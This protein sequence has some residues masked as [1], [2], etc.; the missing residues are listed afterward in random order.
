MKRTTYLILTL[1]L[2][3]G[4]AAAGVVSVS[5]V[6]YKS[7]SGF[8]SGQVFVIDFVAD[9]STDKVSAII[10]SGQLADASGGDVS[11]DLTVDATAT[12]TY[13]RYSIG[14][15]GEPTLVQLDLTAAT[16]D[17][18]SELEQWAVNTCYDPDHDG[19]VEWY[20]HS[21]PAWDIADYK[22]YCAYRNGQY[23]PIGDIAS[24]DE[25]F[26]AE[27]CAEASGKQRECAT[28]SNG[29]TGVG[30]RTSLGEHV[31]IEW[32]GNL[33]TGE[34]APGVD[35]EYALHGNQFD[36]GWRIISYS[37]Y[38]DWTDYTARL[39]S[40]YEDWATGGMSRSDLETQ[41]D[42][43]AEQAASK[44]TD[45][46]L[47]AAT[48]VDSSFTDGQ[49][50]LDLANQLAYPAFTLYVDGAEYITVEKPTG[51]PKIVSTS[52]DTFGEVDTG[53]V[54]MTVENVGE[55][56]GSFAGRVTSCSDGFNFDSTTITQTVNPGERTTYEF[57]VSFTSTGTDGKVSGTCT[58]QVKG[59]ESR[60]M[61][62]ASV[63]GKQ[64]SECK[65]GERISKPGPSGTDV[66]YKCDSDGVGLI[67]LKT[68]PKDKPDT[69]MRDGE[70][71]C[72]APNVQE[73]TGLGASFQRFMS[74]VD[75]FMEDPLGNFMHKPL[76]AIDILATLLAV[77]AAFFLVQSKLVAPFVE[78]VSEAVG[79]N[80]TLLRLV[81]GVVIAVLAGYAT[82]ALISQLWVKI[83]IFVGAIVLMGAYVYIM[84]ILPG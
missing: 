52:G 64:A 16:K 63:T 42:Q 24:P 73:Q 69:T 2:L 79:V 84:A 68:C 31:K 6:N 70:L 25:L 32:N 81:V 49:L 54:S 12:E 30:T 14:P 23:G 9:G 71:V 66:I 77:L 48:T 72:V 46:P 47:T 51:V 21:V 36:G 59:V 29:A 80:E 19:A 43:E 22:G 60:D 74:D 20:Q 11:Q 15:S 35:D 17:T 41:M 76:L 4:V 67:K 33:D 44:F 3:S 82:Y 10:D 65:P 27:F 45:S 61:A 5:S 75:A 8:F 39:P 34:S 83:V 62:T 55:A 58:V 1:T 37:R 28:L 53:T 40:L 78:V 26:T 18:K 13:A 56:E 57:D 7:N 38:D 50:R